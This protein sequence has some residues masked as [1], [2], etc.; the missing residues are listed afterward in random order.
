MQS[1][2]SETSIRFIETAPRV[3]PNVHNE[4]R[5]LFLRASSSIVGFGVMPLNRGTAAAT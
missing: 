1:D 5:A 2:T 3:R 4:E